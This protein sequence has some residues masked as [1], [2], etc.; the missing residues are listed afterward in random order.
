MKINKS[1]NVK[2]FKRGQVLAN[3]LYIFV[4]SVF[5]L[6][7]DP[8]GARP[9]HP[10]CHTSDIPSPAHFWAPMGPEGPPPGGGRELT[11]R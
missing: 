10:S 7:L 8:W 6:F 2:G 4:V 9:G 3:V 5:L 11:H 1:I